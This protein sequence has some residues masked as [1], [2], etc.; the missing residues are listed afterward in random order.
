MRR[1][2][3]ALGISALCMALTPALALGQD[4]SAE[5]P[6]S[7][8]AVNTTGQ[9]IS[10]SGGATQSADQSAHAIQLLP[11]AA[12]PAV[13]AQV[14][15]IN[16]NLPIRLLSPGENATPAQSNTASAPAEATNVNAID[17][18]IRQSGGSADPKNPGTQEASQ[19]AA[20][21][22]V[23]PVAI[24][25]AIAGQVA[26]IN[27][28]AP[29]RIGSPGDN[30]AP[31]QSNTASAPAEATNVNSV[32]QLIRQSGDDK[33]GGTVGSQTASQSAH[34]IQLLPI[35]LA[36]AVAAQVLPVNLN[37]PIRVLSPGDDPAAV[38]QSNTASAPA[39]ATN[40][41]AIDQG[42]GQW[43]GGSQTATQEA[44][45]L[46]LLPIALAPAIAAQVLPVNVNAPISLIDEL[47][48]LPV[49]PFALLADP[50]GTVSGV[51]GG[52]VGFVGSLPLGAVTGLVGGLPLVGGLLPSGLAPAGLAPAAL[53]P[54]A[55][56][57]PL[58]LVGGLV[59]GLP[60]PALPVD[61]F[62]LLADPLGLVTGLLADPFGSVFG[63][64]GSLPLPISII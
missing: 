49:D 54:A 9:G 38:A 20:A 4:N 42:I 43:G 27:V 19:S 55:L 56:P 3:L 11:I 13:A 58:A 35:A 30:A 10:Q 62:A 50:L 22:Q 17:Q 7:A 2:F 31:E 44:F 64:L 24:A 61:P 41:N 60:L 45:A 28:N 23:A 63:L 36:P 14:A 12:A 6:A 48:P 21:I 57:D 8:G 25:P 37:A 29:I 33:K 53:A 16:V 47:P 18:S 39:E 15:P 5:A 1:H 51:V 34:A 40:V 32:D 26:P 59:G 46:Q 52:V